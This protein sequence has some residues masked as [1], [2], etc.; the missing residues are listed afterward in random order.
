MA[1]TLADP[2]DPRW[3]GD[4]TETFKQ[5][6]GEWGND[7]G[8]PSGTPIVSPYDGTVVHTESLGSTNWGDRIVIKPDDPS[9]P[10][11][12]VGHLRSFTVAQ[13]QHVSKDQLIGYS[14]GGLSDPN[15]GNTTGPH[16]EYQVIRP[17]GS[18]TNPGDYVDPH[19]WL[20]AIFGHNT[21]FTMTGS[22][23]PAD[24]G[25]AGASSGTAAVG[26]P[27]G[28]G[29]DIAG[30]V[31]SAFGSAIAGTAAGVFTALGHGVA[32]FVGAIVHNM[33]EFFRTEGVPLAVAAVVLIVLMS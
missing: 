33:G 1:D 6:P 5:T 16:I 14:G 7:F 15:H 22:T 8:T 3:F 24:P 26:T 13:G 18:Y 20:S 32:N 10:E 25:L 28:L 29:S 27:V 2:F 30:A 19:P 21:G 12:A 23:S 31:G 17:G 9:L 4:V 11:T